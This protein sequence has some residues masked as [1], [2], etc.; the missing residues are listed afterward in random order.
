[1]GWI[2]YPLADL[3]L[4]INSTIWGLNDAVNSSGIEPRVAQQ[5]PLINKEVACVDIVYNF[6]SLLKQREEH[7]AN[8]QDVKQQ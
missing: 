7:K 5:K 2:V 3:A 6:K 1:M 4:L 8:K